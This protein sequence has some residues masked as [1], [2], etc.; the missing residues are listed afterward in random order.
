[1]GFEQ[2]AAFAQ[3]EGVLLSLLSEGFLRPTGRLARRLSA[4]ELRTAFGELLAEDEATEHALGLL[5]ASEA[6]LAFASEEEA[7]LKL[8]VEYNRLFVGPGLVMAPP[9]ESYFASS[10]K[11]ARGRLRGPEEREV[12]RIY[13]AHGF[14]VPEA[15]GELADHIAV[16]LAF[17]SQVAL[18]E[19][20]LWKAGEQ[21]SAEQL[22]ADA[23]AFRAAHLGRWIADFASL[24]NEGARLSFYPALAYLT[25]EV[26]RE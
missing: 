23:D 21:Q 19:A 18:N 15:G 24:V 11:G 14:A 2:E 10:S 12:A 17:L 4:G 5:E 16:E 8:E 9:Y 6:E 25:Q 7:R 13:R 1:M 26:V 20:V 22:Q 3:A